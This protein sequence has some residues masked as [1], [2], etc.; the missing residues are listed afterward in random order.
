M[1][2]YD[3]SWDESWA[4]PNVIKDEL[5]AASYDVQPYPGSFK[6]GRPKWIATFLS[7]DRKGMELVSKKTGAGY[8]VF[9]RQELVDRDTTPR[10]ILKRAEHL[11]KHHRPTGPGIRVSK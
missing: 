4:Y 3:K 10:A 11:C 9:S 8:K 7:G 6:S 1:S 5:K 2:T